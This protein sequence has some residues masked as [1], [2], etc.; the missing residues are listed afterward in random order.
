[1]GGSG[2]GKTSLIDVIMDAC[3]ANARVE[4]R[5]AFDGRD[6]RPLIADACAYVK[7]G[8][9]LLPQLTA[10]ETLQFAARLR[11]PAEL[12]DEERE[13]RV[14]D[15]IAELG[16]KECADT[17]VGNEFARGLSGGEKRRVSIG[18]QLLTDPKLLFLDEPTTGAQQSSAHWSSAGC[19]SAQ[20][21]TSV[22]GLTLSLPLCA[23]DTHR[24]FDPASHRCIEA[25]ASTAS[26]RTMLS[27]TSPSWLRKAAQLCAAFTSRALTFSNCLT[28][29]CCWLAVT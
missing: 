1:M 18:I 24:F 17:R 22:C 10:R 7:Q 11:L 3:G 6:P 28:Q 29:F 23:S 19:C 16:L 21:R 14:N 27:S 4:G 5:V 13:R 20:H 8:D 2:S 15:V 9:F 12:S 26:L 25:Q